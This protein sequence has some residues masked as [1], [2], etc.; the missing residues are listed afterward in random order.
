[1]SDIIDINQLRNKVTEKDVNE[2]R[3]F[4]FRLYD[5]LAEGKLFVGEITEQ[6][7]QYAEIKGITEEK[8]CNLREE[9]IKEL[10]EEVGFN[11]KEIEKQIE[12]TDLN[13]DFE[14]LEEQLKFYDTNIKNISIKGVFKYRINNQFNDIL[15]IFEGDKGYILTQRKPDFNDKDLKNIIQDYKQNH[16][17]NEIEVIVLKEIERHKL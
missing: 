6:M 5:K 1:M 16:N 15:I 10:T 17:K 12:E 2:F 14:E 9:L 8:L 11:F 7:D 4:I 3:E 13:L